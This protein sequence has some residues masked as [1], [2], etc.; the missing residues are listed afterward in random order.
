MQPLPELTAP[1]AKHPHI[2]M[3]CSLVPAREGEGVCQPS[4]M[5]TPGVTFILLL[6]PELGHQEAWSK[7]RSQHGMTRARRGPSHPITAPP[8]LKGS[9][10]GTLRG[11][12]DE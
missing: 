12:Q 8:P 3:G 11:S 1:V 7:Q 10:L 2:G 5:P 4:R 9:V 6:G